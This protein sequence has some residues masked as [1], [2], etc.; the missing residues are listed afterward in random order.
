MGDQGAGDLPPTSFAVSAPREDER[1][2]IHVHCVGEWYVSGKSDRHRLEHGLFLTQG[3]AA[4]FTV[5][6]IKAV[7]RHLRVFDPAVGGSILCRAAV[8]ALASRNQRPSTI[9]LVAHEI[10]GGLFAPLRAILDHVAALCL[11]CA[12]RLRTSS[13]PTSGCWIR[14]TGPFPSKR[15]QTV[16]ISMPVV[17]SAGA[18]YVSA[19]PDF[20]EFR[21]HMKA[22]A[23]ETEV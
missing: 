13:W 18:V 14:M 4:E 8:E 17:C 12:W 6:R 19:F 3:P 2:A 21:K 11:P 16:S 23:W 9:G 20:A 7:G 5:E 22:I 10:D 1:P 15:I